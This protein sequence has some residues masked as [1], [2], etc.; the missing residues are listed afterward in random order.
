[1]YKNN[2]SEIC[3]KI[4]VNNGIVETKIKGSDIKEIIKKD[5]MD[6]IATNNDNDEICS[7]CMTY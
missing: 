6:N 2:K 5:F 1:M 3:A 7:G 4:Q